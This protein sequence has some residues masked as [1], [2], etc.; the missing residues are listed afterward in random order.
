VQKSFHVF[1][2]G[3]ESQRPN[4]G[5]VAIEGH[6]VVPP[7]SAVLKDEDLPPAFGPKVEEF[8][9]RAAQEAGEIEV[10]VSNASSACFASRVIACPGD[11]L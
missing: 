5:G 1:D 3:G 6:H 7:C 9:A 11:T 8:V 4:A 10:A 2:R